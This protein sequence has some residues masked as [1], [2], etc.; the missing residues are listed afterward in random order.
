MYQKI[1]ETS[2]DKGETSALALALENKHSLV[3]INEEKGRKL[4]KQ[5]G[6]TVTGTLGV[7]LD[8][9]FTGHIASLKSTINKIKQTN[10]RL[11]RELE[12]KLLQLAGE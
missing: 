2:L 4:A 10:F 8:A 7:L 5:L 3:I 12:T 6:I 1:L 9:K 11:S